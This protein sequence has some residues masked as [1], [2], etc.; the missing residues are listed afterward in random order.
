VPDRNCNNIPELCDYNANCISTSNGWKC[1]CN[2]GE[3]PAAVCWSWSLTIYNF[4]GFI[5]NGSVCKEP[6]KLETGFL[7]VSQGVAAVKIPLSGSKRG[8]PVSTASMWV[9]QVLAFPVKFP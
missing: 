6:P 7:I 3:N 2:Q 5:G 8:T 9:H 1:V 4:P